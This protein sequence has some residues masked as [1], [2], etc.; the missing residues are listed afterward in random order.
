VSQ[1]LPKPND[2]KP[3]DE[4]LK[5]KSKPTSSTT[6]IIQITALL[7]CLTSVQCE[8][9][10]LISLLND[11]VDDNE[12]SKSI[13]YML[14]NPSSQFS[15]IVSECRSIIVAGGTMHPLSEFRDQLFLQAGAK[16]DRVMNFS[17]DHVVP[18][19]NILP[20]VVK[21]GPSGKP[22]EFSFKTRDEIATIDELGRVI[23]NI[24]NMVPGGVVIFFPSYAYE[25]KVYAH[26]DKTGVL[27]RILKKKQ[28]FREPK[29]GSEMDKVL[30]D[31]ARNACKQ[32]AILLSVVGGK[33]S[34]GINFSDD[35]GRCVL[36]VG[37]P[38]PNI[39]SPELKERM[40]Y[41][42]CNAARSDDGRSAGQVHYE[43]LCMKAV[44]QSIGRAIR[45]KGDYASIILVDNR[46]SRANIIKQLPG[47]I[48]K[49][50]IV[51]EK[52][53]PIIPKLHK[54]YKQKN[55]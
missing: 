33:M 26:F 37:L 24:C 23:C 44:N 27:A 40:E 31:Y 14:L 18:G 30:K 49:H 46:Y 41:L 12:H 19:E 20:L 42:D 7:K 50:V 1:T 21:N 52:F 54:F 22:L 43:N 51:E 45:H 39:M 28:I 10:I 25:K 35:L 8:G 38:Y 11:A 6:P 3:E 48:K 17:C 47:W 4:N 16:I 32:G 34:E 9:R 53:G 2:E 15:D 36:M 29:K 13:K 5:S 55:L